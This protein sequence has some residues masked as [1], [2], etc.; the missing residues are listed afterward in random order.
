MPFGHI[1]EVP[2]NAEWQEL[3]A[4]ATEGP[5]GNT[6]VC[7]LTWTVPI[8]EGVDLP[9]KWRAFVQKETHRPLR[10]ELY[11]YDT[12]AGAYELQTARTVEY[13][14]EAQAQE[15]IADFKR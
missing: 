8:S 1:S 6:R 15:L 12:D 9:Y 10:I 5:F 11:G 14:T 4:S 7:E 13:L 3:D 2:E